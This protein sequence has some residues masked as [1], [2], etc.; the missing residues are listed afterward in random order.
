MDR[1]ERNHQI[2]DGELDDQQ[3]MM[4]IDKGMYYGLNP[5]GKRIWDMLEKP[6]S[7][8]EMTQTLLQEFEVSEQQCKKEVQE[9]LDDAIE[10]DILKKV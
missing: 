1:Y 2:I 5:I 6:K 9:F 3:V 7:F 4:H 8:E 10:K